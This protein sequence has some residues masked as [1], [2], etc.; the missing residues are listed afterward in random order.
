MLLTKVKFGLAL[1]GAGVVGGVLTAGGFVM[2]AQKP[3]PQ[4]SPTPTPT[5]S[6]T[7][8]P[9]PTPT[10]SAKATA[11]TAKSDNELITAAA[12]THAMAV[13]GSS[14]TPTVKILKI[15]GNFAGTA[16]TPKGSQSAISQILKKANNDWTVVYQGNG[17]P[18]EEEMSIY[19]IPQGFL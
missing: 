7:P 6:L 1:A 12:T 13:A 16:V 3:Q 14:G 15:S 17:G 11:P 8:S 4:V 19:G 5:P 10:A 2:T 18:S 9:L